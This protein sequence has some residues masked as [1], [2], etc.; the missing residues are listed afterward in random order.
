M[1]FPH[2]CKRIPSN[3]SIG[4]NSNNGR[5]KANWRYCLQWSGNIGIVARNGHN[6]S[7][8]SSTSMEALSSDDS[9]GSDGGN[10]RSGS[11]IGKW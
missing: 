9:I 1:I 8:S 4:S 11:N 2:I 3:S 5:N 10:C 7:I 6:D